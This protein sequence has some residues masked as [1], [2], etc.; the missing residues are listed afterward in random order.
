[1]SN[2]S[3]YSLFLTIIVVAFVAACSGGGKKAEKEPES[4]VVA[5]DLH[6]HFIQVSVEGMTCEG[7]QNTVKGAITKIEGVD[8]VSASFTDARAL[9]GYSGKVPDTAA[10]RTAVTD[11]GYTVKGFTFLA[12]EH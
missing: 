6:L 3:L 7:C 2:K 9:A 5:E 4:V 11:A 1:M 10:I 8:S 12:H